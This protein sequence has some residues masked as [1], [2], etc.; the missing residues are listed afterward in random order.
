MRRSLDGFPGARMAHGP[1]NKT[2]VESNNSVSLSP[3]LWVFLLSHQFPREQNIDFDLKII[4]LLWRLHFHDLH[5]F[6]GLG[7]IKGLFGLSRGMR[8]TECHSSLIFLFI[9][10]YTCKSYGWQVRFLLHCMAVWCQHTECLSLN[11]W[12]EFRTKC[13]PAQWLVS[14]MHLCLIL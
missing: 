3:T 5:C 9:T 6:V 10:A 14:L 8:S 1:R 11:F 4:L 2:G 12:W 13:S 7:W